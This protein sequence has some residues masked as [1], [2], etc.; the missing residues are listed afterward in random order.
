MR[1]KLGSCF[2]VVSAW[3]RTST[4]KNILSIA[5][6]LGKLT[7][8]VGILSYIIEAPE[9]AKQQHYQAWQLINGARTS[10]GEAGRSIAIGVLVGDH[11]PLIDLD[12]KKGNFQDKDFR[13]AQ[14]PGVDFTEANVDRVNF[15]CKTGFYVSE[16]WIPG[17]DYCL[18]TNLQA[19]RFATERII[20]ANFDYANLKDATIG[21]RK[22]G[23]TTL[24][25]TTFLHTTMSNTTIQTS[26]VRNATFDDADLQSS[27]WLGGDLLDKN[28][29]I[30]A[31]LKKARWYG[32]NFGGS[33]QI[34]FTDADLSEIRVSDQIGPFPDDVLLETDKRLLKAKLCRTKFSKGVSNRDCPAVAPEQPD[35]VWVFRELQ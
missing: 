2:H 5:E 12:L 30:R 6:A 1:S 18:P 16:H 29:F 17:F 14:M 13:G 11:V 32:L 9:R 10:P 28:S 35:N 15:S 31:N 4:A 34:D 8:V 20:K 21:A 33:Q 24:E 22:E 27:Q 25:D 3:L 26:K 19:A 7:V 23:V